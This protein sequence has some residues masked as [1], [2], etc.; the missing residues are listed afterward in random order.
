MRKGSSSDMRD[1][2][3]D[4]GVRMDLAKAIAFGALHADVPMEK[5]LSE[6][7]T[8]GLSMLP[9]GSASTRCWFSKII[10]P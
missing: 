1:F 2:V 3:Y 5:Y 7:S 10:I 6:V 8:Q 9:S 4:G